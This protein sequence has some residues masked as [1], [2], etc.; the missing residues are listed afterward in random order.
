MITFIVRLDDGKK[1]TFEIPVSYETAKDIFEWIKLCPE[2][3]SIVF[4]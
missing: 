1:F 2:I 3:A 4:G